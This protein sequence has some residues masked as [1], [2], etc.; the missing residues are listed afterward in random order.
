MRALS[1][2]SSAARTST[3]GILIPV[4]TNLSPF[5]GLKL[6]LAFGITMPRVESSFLTQIQID[7]SCEFWLFLFS[8][9]RVSVFNI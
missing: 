5:F 6:P 1:S 8:S 3:E 9:I 2:L 7:S 4:M